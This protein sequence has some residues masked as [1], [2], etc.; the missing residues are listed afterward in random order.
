MHIAP[1]GVIF[2]LNSQKNLPEIFWVYI[3]DSILRCV[4][5]ALALQ[6]HMFELRFSVVPVVEFISSEGAPCEASQIQ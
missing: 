5:L 1:P 6:Y 2:V 3:Y 4:I